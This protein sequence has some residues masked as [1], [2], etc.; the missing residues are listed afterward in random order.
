MHHLMSNSRCYF[1]LTLLR[2]LWKSSYNNPFRLPRRPTRAMQEWSPF[3]AGIPSGSLVCSNLGG[4]C[5]ILSQKTLVLYKELA[6]GR[7]STSTGGFINQ[8]H[9]E[10]LL[11]EPRAHHVSSSPVNMTGTSKFLCKEGPTDNIKISQL[12]LAGVYFTVIFP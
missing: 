4:F 6:V 10:V 3:L 2:S 9:L 5:R 12:S 7:D 11:R 1:H 8:D